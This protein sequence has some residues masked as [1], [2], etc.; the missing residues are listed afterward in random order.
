MTGRTHFLTAEW[1]IEAE[2]LL[3]EA[4]AI[5]RNFPTLNGYLAACDSILLLQEV[6]DLQTDDLIN[7]VLNINGNRVEGPFKLPW[8]V[9]FHLGAYGHCCTLFSF[10]FNDYKQK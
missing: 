5:A 6:Y 8:V 1:P 10:S 4:V 9:C 7:G 2:A 3:E